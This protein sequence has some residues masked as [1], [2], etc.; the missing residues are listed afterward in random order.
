MN[1]IDP[2]A[3]WPAGEAVGLLIFAEDSSSRL[4]DP[5]TMS[6]VLD[7]ARHWW[8]AVARN[9]AVGP[10]VEPPFRNL[11]FVELEDPSAASALVDELRA[12]EPTSTTIVAASPISP[13]SARRFRRFRSFM[14]RLPNPSRTGGSLPPDYEGD[15]IPSDAQLRSMHTMNQEGPVLVLSLNRYRD[16]ASDPLTG[17]QQTG[18]EVFRPY[19][20]HTVA[21]FSRMGAHILWMGHSH[22]V[23]AGALDMPEWHDIMAVSY[24]SY[25]AVSRM[26][27]NP[28][29]QS[30]ARYR[31]AGLESSWIV[32]GPLVASSES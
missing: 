24:P 21:A 20:R 5:N 31:I 14:R 11:Y 6:L 19:F 22:G 29:L 17:V 8:S 30:K 13:K 1:N 9:M 15:L 12:T 2:F 23:V 4:S 32:M 27:E 28:G 3:K 7:T 10:S 26:I 25:D 18:R 16:R